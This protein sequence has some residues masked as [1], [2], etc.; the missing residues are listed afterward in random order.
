[1]SFTFILF[2]THNCLVCH[3]MIKIRL[4]FFITVVLDFFW[5]ISAFFSTLIIPI[6]YH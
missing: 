1:M 4:W 6:I 3:F 2:I 5:L